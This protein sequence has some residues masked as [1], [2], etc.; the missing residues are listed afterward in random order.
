MLAFLLPKDQKD[1]KVLCSGRV[2]K[3]CVGNVPLL[4]KALLRIALVLWINAFVSIDQ[5]VVVVLLLG[6]T[7]DVF[8]VNEADSGNHKF[9][10]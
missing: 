7:L 9:E 6:N 2:N 8:C 1:P 10:V 3:L 4:G 5:F